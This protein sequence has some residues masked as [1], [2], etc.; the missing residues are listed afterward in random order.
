MLSLTQ[1]FLCLSLQDGWTPL[2]VAV[3]NGYAGIVNLL[4]KSEA[5]VNATKEVR[6]ALM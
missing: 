2:H 6:V 4:I 3:D 5:N 1:Y